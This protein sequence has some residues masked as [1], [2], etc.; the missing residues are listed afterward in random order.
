MHPEPRRDTTIRHWI[1]IVPSI[2]RRATVAGGC[3]AFLD[4]AER[5]LVPALR[6]F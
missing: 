6:G 1:D 3:V 5:E 4:F 2:D